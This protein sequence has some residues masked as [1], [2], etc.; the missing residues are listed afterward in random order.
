MKPLAC[1]ALLACAFAAQAFAIPEPTSPMRQISKDSDNLYQRYQTEIS[2]L[3]KALRRYYEVEKSWPAS[4]DTLSSKGYVARGPQ[5]SLQATGGVTRT[6]AFHIM[7]TLPSGRAGE[8]L[9]TRLAKTLGGTAQRTTVTIQLTPVVGFINPDL[10]ID[11]VN[12]KA[13]STDINMNNHWIKNSSMQGEV[14]DV[15]LAK[16]ES[17]NVERDV[18]FQ[19]S[20]KVGRSLK[21][22][23]GWLGN[24]AYL[25]DMNSASLAAEKDVTIQQGVSAINAKFNDQSTFQG[26][27]AVNNNLIANADVFFRSAMIVRRNTVINSANF[28]GE[29]VANEKIESLGEI[30]SINGDFINSDVGALSAKNISSA[31]LDINGELRAKD[32]QSHTVISVNGDFSGNLVAQGLLTKGAINAMNGLMV[33][34]E[35]VLVADQDGALYY[36][37]ETLSSLFLGKDGKAADSF[38]LDGMSKDELSMLA[39]SNTHSGGNKFDRVDVNNG[40]YAGSN[41]VLDADGA[42]FYESGSPLDKK[43]L[44]IGDKASDSFGLDG[45]SASSLAQ[46]GSGNVF[47]DKASFLSGVNVQGDILSGGQLMAGKG[48]LYEGGTPLTKKYLGKNDKAVDSELLDG[49]SSSHFAQLGAPNIFSGSNSFAGDINVGGVGLLASV[50]N[51]GQRTTSLEGRVDSANKALD[52]LLY[53]KSRCKVHAADPGCRFVFVPKN[54]TETIGDGNHYVEDASFTGNPYVRWVWNGQVLKHTGPERLYPFSMGGYTYSVAHKIGARED[55]S[56]W[57]CEYPDVT[58]IYAITRKKN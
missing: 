44:G 6:G 40:V 17:L 22:F 1:S 47:T 49:I 36:R 30:K 29:F 51:T 43:Y 9:A 37:G 54:V 18:G 56:C 7:V 52:N 55:N 11:R 38:L 27:L 35:N 25:T 53:I 26:A 2:S 4:I 48:L 58:I 8:H 31:K 10:Y 23:N 57:D 19:K 5:K 39:A 34:P 46:I 20:L 15:R 12:P 13:M 14:I 41:I 28:L 50:L 32:I 16:L 3:K 42:H 21:S 24:A 45:Y 33:G